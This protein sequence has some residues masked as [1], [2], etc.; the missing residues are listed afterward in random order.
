MHS[1]MNRYQNSVFEPVLIPLIYSRKRTIHCKMREPNVLCISRPIIAMPI[2][3]LTNQSH[4]P[5]LVS[6]TD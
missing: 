4:A 6:G 3:S 5:L 2:F 1:R